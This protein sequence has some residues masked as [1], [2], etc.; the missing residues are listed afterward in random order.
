MITIIQNLIY[1]KNQDKFD[2]VIINK[3]DKEFNR[4]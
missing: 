4:L 1:L 3:N 2:Y